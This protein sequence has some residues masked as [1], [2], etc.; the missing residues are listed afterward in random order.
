VSY[1]YL[2]RGS[3]RVQTFEGGG[4]MARDLLLKLPEVRVAGPDEVRRP[5]PRREA[6]ISRRPR[7]MVST[8]MPAISA[9]R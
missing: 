8:S 5:Y 7:R 6:S 2:S 3:N 1:V 9:R 4:K